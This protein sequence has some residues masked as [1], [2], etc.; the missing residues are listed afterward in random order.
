MAVLT[1]AT[2]VSVLSIGEDSLQL[3]I[4]GTGATKPSAEFDLGQMNQQQTSQPVRGD[5]TGLVGGARAKDV[6][7]D[8]NGL[9]APPPQAAA[10]RFTLTVRFE[11]GAGCG[12]R[13]QGA[14]LEGA[15]AAITEVALQRAVAAARQEGGGL[16]M[17]LT[18]VQGMLLD[19][20]P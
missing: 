14:S 19:E 6:G 1:H 11:P 13:L 15:P 2:G 18:L 9:A 5:R 20:E 17:L 3:G 16:P 12:S 7:A 10:P 4:G 8:R